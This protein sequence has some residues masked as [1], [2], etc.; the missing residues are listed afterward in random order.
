MQSKKQ[1]KQFAKK[2]SFND[3]AVTFK[4]YYIQFKLN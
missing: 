2:I 4:Y 1:F 3:Y